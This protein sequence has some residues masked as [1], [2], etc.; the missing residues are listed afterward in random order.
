MLGRADGYRSPHFLT[1]DLPFDVHA[2]AQQ[3]AIFPDDSTA[4]QIFNHQQFEAFRALGHHQ[5]GVLV[6]KQADTILDP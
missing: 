5:A 6:K 4:D 3:A 2:W 1:T